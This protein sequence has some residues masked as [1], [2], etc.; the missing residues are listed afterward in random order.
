MAR[1]LWSPDGSRILYTFQKVVTD[2]HAR[3]NVYI[4]N[5]DGSGLHALTTGDTV[6]RNPV[7]SPDGSH[8]AFNSNL[9]DNRTDEVFT[10]NPDASGLSQL[11][12]GGGLYPSYSPDGKYIVYARHTDAS[13]PHQLYVMNADGSN[14]RQITVDDNDHSFPKWGRLSKD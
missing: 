8:I 10:I 6:D 9:G 2:N 1:P 14:Q 5:A 3:F 13:Q 12:S 4:I 7:W 11:T